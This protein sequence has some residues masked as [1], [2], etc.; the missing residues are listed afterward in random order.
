MEYLFN[1][2]IE[3]LLILS[4]M[5]FSAQK[6][7]A[8]PCAGL[9]FR[10]GHHVCVGLYWGCKWRLIFWNYFSISNRHNDKT[11]KKQQKNAPDSYL[12]YL[13]LRNYKI[14]EG[15]F[16]EIALWPKV[17]KQYFSFFHNMH[18]KKIPKLLFW[19]TFFWG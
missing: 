8:R 19:P 13:F 2:E 11:N 16:L 14:F 17:A 5:F 6:R 4:K 18:N 1:Q 9:P 15:I 7:V 10:V 3:K 12:L